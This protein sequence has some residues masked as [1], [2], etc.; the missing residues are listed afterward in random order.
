MDAP[1]GKAEQKMIFLL[2]W[3]FPPFSSS[4][5][6]G[7][8][9]ESNSKIFLSWN[10]KEI[11][12]DFFLRKFFRFSDRWFKKVY[13]DTTT[14]PRYYFPSQFSFPGTEQG[15]IPKHRLCLSTSVSRVH[16]K[17]VQHLMCRYHMPQFNP[18]S[19]WQQ[20]PFPPG[21]LFC[22][23]LSLHIPSA[24]SLCSSSLGCVGP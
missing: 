9:G 22:L 7:W 1:L 23:L 3:F 15:P 12:R 5:E 8:L 19:M 16:A 21:I 6:V 2:L 18:D 17:R 10:K 14:S 24:P 13:F 11:E 20:D 4:N